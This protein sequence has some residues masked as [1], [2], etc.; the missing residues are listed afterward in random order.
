MP[1][2]ILAF[3]KCSDVSSFVTLPDAA[4][5]TVLPKLGIDP[6]SSGPIT[7]LC[8]N[9]EEYSEERGELFNDLFVFD[10]VTV[11]GLDQKNLYNS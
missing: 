9:Q 11:I 2:N 3:R 4:L 6:E 7:C 8:I 1:L 10:C 5:L